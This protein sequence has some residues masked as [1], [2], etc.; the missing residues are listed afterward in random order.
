MFWWK[1][2][3]Q[4]LQTPYLPGSMLIYWRVYNGIWRGFDRSILG[5]L[6]EI[7]SGNSSNQTW[8]L[9]NPLFLDDFPCCKPLF[10]GDV[11]LP[12]LI[13]R[14]YPYLGKFI[15]RTCF[16]FNH[17]FFLI[18]FWMFY[19][20]TNPNRVLINGTGKKIGQKT[21]PPNWGTAFRDQTVSLKTCSENV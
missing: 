6:W 20:Q 5:R 19:L 14:G 7:P 8:L 21:Q 3:F 10:I 1:L 12:R 16:W 2:I 11:P 17:I 15:E 18:V 9:E 13:A 4:H